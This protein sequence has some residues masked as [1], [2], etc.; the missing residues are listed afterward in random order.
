MLCERDYNWVGFLGDGVRFGVRFFAC[1]KS[2]V[3]DI[4]DYGSGSLLG[5]DLIPTAVSV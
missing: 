2:L 3:F 1:N 5:H 4:C